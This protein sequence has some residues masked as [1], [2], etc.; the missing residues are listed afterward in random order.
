M[1]MYWRVP[2]RH[3]ETKLLVFLEGSIE[4]VVQGRKFNYKLGDKLIIPGNVEHSAI[5]GAR[6]CGFFWGRR[7]YSIEVEV[8]WKR[9]LDSRHSLPAS[10]RRAS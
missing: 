3:P 7:N 10:S 8:R 1:R 2:D 6:G 5:A 4:V 9:E